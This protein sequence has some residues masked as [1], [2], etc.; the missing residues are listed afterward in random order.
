M[1]PLVTSSLKFFRVCGLLL[2][3]LILAPGEQVHGRGADPSKFPEYSVISTNVAF[4][5]KIYSTHSVNTAIIHDQDHLD[6]IYAVLQLSDETQPGARRKNEKI[7]ERTKAKY[8]QL[9]VR[10][11]HNP[12]PQTAEQKRIATLYGS[13]FKAA[14]LKRGAQNIRSQ[15]GLRERFVE[16]VVRSGAYM[17]EIKRIFRSF[18]LPTDLAYLPHVESSFNPR[19]YSKFGAAGMWQ[20]TRST[21]KEFLRIDYI[22]DERRDP[23]LSARAAAQFL[24]RNFQQL[25]S[26]PLALTAYNYGPAGMKRAL[27][28]EGSYENIFRNYRKG[29]F[30]FASRNFYSEFLAAVHVAKQLE[31][32]NQLRLARPVGYVSVRLPAYTD[33]ARLC[34]YL[35]IEN[36][37][38]RRYNPA[39]RDPVFQGTKYIPADYVIRLPARF[40]NNNRLANAPAPLFKTEQKRSKFYQVR[41][42]D[43]AGAIALAHRIS[44]ESLVRVNNLNRQAM[45][46]VGQNLRIPPANGKPAGKFSSKNELTAARTLH[47]NKKMSA[48]EPVPV[49]QAIKADNVVVGNLKVSNIKQNNQLI[50]GTVVV[51]PDES[52]GLFADWLKVTRNSIH[53]ANQLPLKGD[54]H[55]GQQIVLDFLS[56]SIDA[57]EET[58]FDYH[59]EIQ[60]DFFDSYTIIGVKTYRV[61]DGDTVWDICHKK[62][63]IPLWLLHKYNDEL[64]F[65][66]L[67]SSSSLQIPILEQ[68]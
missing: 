1:I 64:N 56:T 22:I 8:S 20:F 30:K 59:Q 4:W 33:A 5:Q 46:R 18:G 35:G 15:R 25:G 47:D 57:F 7:I 2:T 10:L 27:E 11:A 31:L 44:L 39:L 17:A 50:S 41:S 61:E 58:R 13:S 28:Q 52:I 62:F 66:H 23:L 51:Q 65:N 19:A 63:G 54:V 55:P 29:Y 12:Q 67:D 34:T 60:E 68:I 26:W 21:G 45:I 3:I 24:K 9:L 53:A 40:K 6:R 38:L 43:T 16:G 37:E 32:S 48:S 36:N 49:L 42:G 14:A